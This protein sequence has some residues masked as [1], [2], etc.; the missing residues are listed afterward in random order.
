MRLVELREAGVTAATMNR[1]DRAGEASAVAYQLPD[2]D[3][4][5]NTAWQRRALNDGVSRSEPLPDALTRSSPEMSCTPSRQRGQCGRECR[6]I[7]HA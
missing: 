5:L 7:Q 1:M 4:N 6:W 2:A 3:L